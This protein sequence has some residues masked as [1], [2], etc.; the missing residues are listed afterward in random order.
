MEIFVFKNT[1]ALP[2][3]FLFRR[4]NR[5]SGECRQMRRRRL[6]FQ[7]PKALPDIFKE[8]RLKTFPFCRAQQSDSY[9]NKYFSRK[10]RA[11]ALDLKTSCRII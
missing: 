11:L 8:G 10:H 5:Y 6:V 9:P 3:Y 1:R 7:K 2:E 4:N